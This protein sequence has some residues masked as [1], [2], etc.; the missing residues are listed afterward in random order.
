MWRVAIRMLAA[1]RAKF[2][3]LLCGIA[4]AS[5]LVM[6]A[7]AYFSGFMTRGFALIS[8]NPQADVWVMDPA[9]ESTEQTTN[10][11]DSALERVRSVDGVAH[12]D[13]MIL[14]SVDLRFADGRFQPVQVIGVDDATLAGAPVIPASDANAL[15]RSDAAIVDAGGTDEKLLTPSRRIDQWP[16]DGMHPNVPLREVAPGD[17]VL[18]N[19]HRVLIVGRGDLSPRFPPRPL[20]YVTQANA[21][22]IL[23]TEARSLTFVMVT[24]A[25][26]IDPAALAQRIAQ[27]TGLRARTSADFKADTVQWYLVNSEDVGDIATMLTL[28]I[29][30]GLGVTGILLYLFTYENQRHYAVLKAMGAQPHTLVSMVLLQGMTC[31]LLGIGIGSGLCAVAGEI[32]RH[33]GFPFRM[34]WYM[35]LASIVVVLLISA[36]AAVLSLRPVLRLDPAVVFSAR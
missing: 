32:A 21:R 34:L 14:G 23:P 7:A 1:D 6:F 3:G 35:P 19:D 27:R 5:L 30:I 36:L 4:F 28:A 20:L 26:D 33:A 11:S 16:A 17:E 25:R 9:V 24:A 2:Y 22:R 8:E 13:P 31:A 15:R 18:A 10:M 29:T 12:A